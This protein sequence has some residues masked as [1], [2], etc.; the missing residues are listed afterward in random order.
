M[1]LK[2]GPPERRRAPL[3]TLTEDDMREQ[4]ER[5]TLPPPVP[6][7]E[8]VARMMGDVDGDPPPTPAPETSVELDALGADD[9][10]EILAEIGAAYL[11]RLGSRAHVP[12]TTAS[13]EAALGVALDHWA[14]FILSLVDGTASVE[15][16]VDAS[17]LPEIEALRLLCELRD[18][19]LVRVRPPR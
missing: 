13:R 5:E 18:R 11:A 15:D 7:R 19:G 10:A 12:F 1:P 17:S 3:P 14:G 4:G 16:V 9:E 2:P 6:M 8:L